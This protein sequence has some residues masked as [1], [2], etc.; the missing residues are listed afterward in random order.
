MGNQFEDSF[1]VCEKCK[2]SY[3]YYQYES[4][5]FCSKSGE[6]EMSPEGVQIITNESTWK[7]LDNFRK[8]NSGRCPYFK[9]KFNICSV[10]KSIFNKR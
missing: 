9:E 5:S 1:V 7:A 4:E 3:S 2:F 8:Q 6:T 10:F